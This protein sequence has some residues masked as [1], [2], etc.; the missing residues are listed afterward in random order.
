MLR[1]GATSGVGVGVD[2]PGDVDP[3]RA[4]CSDKAFGGGRIEFASDANRV[5]RALLD[6]EAIEVGRAL[7]QVVSGRQVVHCREGAV[8][9]ASLP[10]RQVK[11][12]RSE[13]DV[14]AA[15]TTSIWLDAG[16]SR[17]HAGHEQTDKQ[18][19][20]RGHDG[21]PGETRFQPK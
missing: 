13:P 20:S 19:D 21:Q 9:G 3:R 1:A 5:R 15:P 4:D 12:R 16:G 7:G 8:G 18:N 2:R 11:R 6:G 14:L 10:L 17:G